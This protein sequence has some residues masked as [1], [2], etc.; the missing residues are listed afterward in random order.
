MKNRLLSLTFVALTLSG[1]AMSPDKNGVIKYKGHEVLSQE[2]AKSLPRNDRL[3]RIVQDMENV[4]FKRVRVSKIIDPITQSVLAIYRNQHKVISQYKTMLD[5]HRD[6]M[7]FLMANKGKSEQELQQEMQRFDANMTDDK[8]KITPKVVA[9]RKA[10]D[11]IW[12]EN[13][14]LSLKIAEASLVLA[15][16]I[17]NSSDEL[18]DKEGLMLLLNGGKVIDVYQLS[19]VRLHLA[20]LA[21]EFIDDEKAIIDITKQLQRQ[22]NTKIKG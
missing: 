4:G 20:K 11:K 13:V 9:Y 2:Q 15:H 12:Q 19:E 14:K 21:N 3:T 8:D 1:C 22:Q 7:S 10:T 6:V 18:L 16:T 5:N 17:H